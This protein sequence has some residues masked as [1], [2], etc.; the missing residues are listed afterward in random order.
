MIST[1]KKKRIKKDLNI[2]IGK[3]PKKVSGPY[4]MM[5]SYQKLLQERNINQIIKSIMSTLDLHGDIL[6]IIQNT[7]EENLK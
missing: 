6:F 5:A 3:E 4:L 7:K 2:M 1:Q